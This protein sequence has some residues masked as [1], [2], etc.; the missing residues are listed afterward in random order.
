MA[1][2]NVTEKANGNF[3]NNTGK[4]KSRAKAVGRALRDF[5]RKAYAKTIAPVMAS[6]LAEPFDERGWIYEF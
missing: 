6:L 3:K 4:R 2:N 1:S 5:P